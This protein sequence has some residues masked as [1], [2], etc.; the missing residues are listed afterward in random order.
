MLEHLFSSRTRVKLLKRFLLNPKEKYYVR[1][2]T[3]DIN[4]RINSVRRELENLSKLGLLINFT[5]NQ[6]KYYQV[7][8]DFLLYPELTALM[9]KAQSLLEDK[10]VDKLRKIKNIKY[11]VLTGRFVQNNEV[12]TDLLIVGNNLNQSKVKDV[13]KRLEKHFDQE[14]NYTIMTLQEFSHR[15]E[16]TDKFIYNIINSPK[17]T[18]VDKIFSVKK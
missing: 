17:I 15:S 18:V 4:E 16:M 10:L 9:T 1:E 7:N 2:L 6:K 3:R 12:Q 13:I 5:Q 8:T 14:L 11:C